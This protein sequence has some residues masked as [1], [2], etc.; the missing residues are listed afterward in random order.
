MWWTREQLKTRAKAVLKGSYWKAFLVSII[1]GL[2]GGGRNGVNF[3]NNFNRN[4]NNR[5]GGYFDKPFMDYTRDMIP[6]IVPIITVIIGVFLLVLCIRIF[7]GYAIEI[8]GRRYFVKAAEYDVNLNNLGYS[9]NGERYMG[10]IK[11]MLYKDVLVFLWTLL[12]IIP[13]VIKSYAYKMVPYILADNPNIGHKRAI[14]ISNAMTDGEKFNI[15][16]LELSFIGWYLLG[17]LAFGIG[18]IFV[19]PYVNAT[20]AELYLIFRKKA[21]DTGMCSPEELM[22][23]E[24]TK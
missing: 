13:G 3:Q 6:Y 4:G 5:Y 22:I 12:L 2:L 15:W 11:T 19:P 14:E 20:E 17:L 16:V 8:G 10:I 21:I 7:I 23:D 18:M 24:F 9:F 1:M